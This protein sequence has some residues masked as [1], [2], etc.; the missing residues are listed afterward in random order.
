MGLLRRMLAA[1]T[2]TRLYEMRKFSTESRT[3][4][5]ISA[6]RG[7]VIVPLEGLHHRIGLSLFLRDGDGGGQ[8]RAGRRGPALGLFWSRLLESLGKPRAAGRREPH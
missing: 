2:A 6:Q 4:L 1:V 5:H 8:G 3:H 7:P